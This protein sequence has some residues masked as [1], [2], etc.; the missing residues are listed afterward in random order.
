MLA[1]CKKIYALLTLVVVIASCFHASS[2]L[3]LGLGELRVNS[4]LNEPLD[5]TIQLLGLD[6]LNDNQIIAAMGSPADFDR[7]D[8]QRTALIDT[9][10]FEVIVLNSEEGVLILSS[11][12]PV[13]EPFLG[14][15]V[16]VRWPTGR[17]MRNYTALIDLPL[18]ISDQEEVVPLDMPQTTAPVQEEIPE[19]EP[20]AEPQ[21]RVL[22]SNEPE[23]PQTSAP[24]Q[25]PAPVAEPEPEQVVAES[26]PEADLI[27]DTEP[28]SS[29]ALEE[30]VAEIAEEVAEEETVTIESGDNLYDIAAR[31]RPSTSVSVEQT[32]LA[33][34]RNNPDAF[35]DNN[36]NMIRVGQVLRIP[37][38][39]EIESIDQAQALNQIA[40]QNQA[41][42]TQPLAFSDNNDAG[43][44]LGSDELTILSGEDGADSISGDS[45]LAETIA[46]LENQLAISEENLDRARL[47]NE[48]LR[49][50][51]AELEEQV[52]ILQ[53]IIAMQ[54]ERLA[55]L[56]ADLAA[57]AQVQE[58]E[59]VAAEEVQSQVVDTPAQPPQQDDS[60]TGQL[61]RVFENT[62]V[63]LSSLVA[64]I[65]LVVGF[66][67]WRRR[68]ALSE[69][70]DYELGGAVAAG[71]PEVFAEEE[72]EGASAGFVAALKNRF[73]SADESEDE[74][75]EIE[76]AAED[77]YLEDEE[78]GGLL[79]KLK[80]I[81]SRS[82]DD[83]WDDDTALADED[84]I[85]DDDFDAD[86]DEEYLDE[87]F[88]DNDLEDTFEETEEADE[89]ESEESAHDEEDDVEELIADV[90]DEEVDADA[91][92]TDEVEPEDEI[93]AFDDSAEESGEAETE[94]I[95]LDIDEV[96]EDSD[97]VS[98]EDTEEGEVAKTD[99]ADL[100]LGDFA[101]EESVVEE[102]GADLEDA[103]ESETSQA[104]DDA[105][106]LIEE[107]EED[108]VETFDFD[109]GDSSETA[110]PEAQS[111]EAPEIEDVESFDFSLD[112]SVQPEE[113]VAANEE[114]DE[115]D[116]ESFDFNIDDSAGEPA[117]EESESTQ[118]D[119][120]EDVES[121]EFKIDEAAAAEAPAAEEPAAE[122]EVESFEFDVSSVSSFEEETTSEEEAAP[123]EDVETIA[124]DDAA[125][126]SDAIIEIDDGEDIADS[127]AEESEE[128][129]DPLAAALDEI[130]AQAGEES[131]DSENEDSGDDF[132]LGNIDIDDSLFEQ[133]DE[134]A[135][136]APITDRDESSTKLDLAVAYEAMGDLDGAREILEEVIAEGNDTQIAEAKK[137]LE[138]WQN[139]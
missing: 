68:A 5:A 138:K 37:S 86:P 76:D 104:E 69:M 72:P 137:L 89:S 117:A 109:L 75:G 83:D 106:K 31:T 44:Q 50:R 77:H 103:P 19:P 27:A 112:D 45:D 70:D 33:I 87:S 39:Q 57:S 71:D 95:D 108:S 8:V 102:S 24:A 63:L 111:D 91:E 16:T 118:E 32:M 22:T 129:V 3:A 17:L 62:V 64:L 41:T 125:F 13:S 113:I 124:P 105:G 4:S 82:D 92:L 74:A 56:Q 42:T 36:V 93:V 94:E 46:A 35:I 116:V 14:M 123:D 134:E 28:E 73:T 15:L 61:S 110:A 6:G 55:Q 121:F 139:S 107:S 54:D 47:E 12:E 60:L 40:L 114:A 20:Q 38:I 67:V 132:D 78:E 128:E 34:Q 10:D 79:S 126:S 100:D 99:E 101:A 7:A 21:P 11:S 66:L 133:E 49:S 1:G 96:I 120:A 97:D 26:E 59:P 122:E 115:E 58:P 18:F 65:L 81:F 131:P 25:E 23:A 29:A 98:H 48:E 127:L 53:N 84:E 85:E 2:A 88:D 9:V 52:E 43:A 30:E 51:F 80:G 90:F 119:V 136:E 130:D 135:A